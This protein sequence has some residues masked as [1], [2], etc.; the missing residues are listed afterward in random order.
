M[1]FVLLLL[2]ICGTALVT[3]AQKMRSSDLSEA[4]KAY[5]QGLELQ[6]ANDNAGAM[7]AYTRAVAL[8]PDY[9]D[10]FNNRGYIKMGQGDLAGA[11]A[12]FGAAIRSRPDKFEG[13]LNRGTA[14]LMGIVVGMVL[15]MAIV[16]SG[17]VGLL[18]AVPGATPI[19][20]ALA[21]I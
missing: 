7:A 18:L 3:P 8:D 14:Y 17:L 6:G 2:L 20:T 13:Y 12:D 19:V 10:A 9:A 4:E 11:V 1:K 5:N 15:V 21:A 16:A